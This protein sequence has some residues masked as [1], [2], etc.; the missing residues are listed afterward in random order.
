[1]SRAEAFPSDMSLSSR[2]FSSLAAGPEGRWRLISRVFYSV[3]L[4]Y[5]PL[6][7]G[8]SLAADVVVVTAGGAQI[9][10]PGYSKD[11][12]PQKFS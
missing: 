4:K 5:F 3:F 8:W 12:S 11:T 9:S 6:Q 10:L 1:M 7:L 2:W